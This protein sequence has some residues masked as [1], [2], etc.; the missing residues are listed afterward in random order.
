MY[1]ALL[2]KLPKQKQSQDP[3]GDAHTLN[4]A[5]DRSADDGAW[6][7]AEAAYTTVIG[8]RANPPPSFPSTHKTSRSV[9][10]RCPRKANRVIA[11]AAY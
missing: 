8:L 6:F 10:P 11:Y 3:T 1:F 7:N 9:R 2:L 5:P 4:C